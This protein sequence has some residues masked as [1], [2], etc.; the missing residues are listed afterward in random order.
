[1]ISLAFE[2]DT[3]IMEKL[4]NMQ[5]LLLEQNNR[6]IMMTSSNA[7]IFRVTDPLCG[8]FTGHW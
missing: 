3:A 7:N 8:E 5:V 6:N 4:Y 2:I 1:M